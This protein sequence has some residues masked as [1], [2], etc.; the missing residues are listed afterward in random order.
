ML[1]RSFAA[2]GTLVSKL[3]IAVV[4]HLDADKVVTALEERGHRLTRI[5]TI[6][7]FL[8][9]GNTTILMGVGDDALDSVLATI[10]EN[11]SSREVDLPPVVVGRL[12]EKLPGLVRYGGAT[13]FV[14]DLQQI[15][16]F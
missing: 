10:E 3:L 13:V 6:G 15:V 2:R 9:I 7:G 1:V 14:A 5:P 16:R 8:G 12:T 4:H 11:C